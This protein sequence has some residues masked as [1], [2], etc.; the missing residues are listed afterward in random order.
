VCPQHN[1]KKRK[2]CDDDVMAHAAKLHWNHD[3]YNN[4]LASQLLL[5]CTTGREY[6]QIW[7]DIQTRGRFLKEQ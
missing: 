5:R 7:D 2:E 3:M 6:F 4:I 1:N